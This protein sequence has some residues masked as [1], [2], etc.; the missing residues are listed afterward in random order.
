MPLISLNVVGAGVV[1]AEPGAPLGTRL[2]AALAAAPHKPVVVMIHGFR[3]TPDVAYSNP[4]THILALDPRQDCWK[5]LSWPRH[6]G[7]GRNAEEGLAIGLGWQAQGTIWA[8]YA[9]A[10][11]AGVALAG[12]IAAIR[13]V[14]PG[15]K[16]DVVAHSLGARVVLAALPLA[17][18][19]A[20][21]RVI[22][23]AAAE[24]RTTAE[25]ARRT[26]AGQGA[27]FIN[28]VT[29]ENDLFDL[30]LEML[31]APP[32]PGCR[33]LGLGLAAPARNWLDMQVDQ[34]ATIAALAA[35]GHRIA[36]PHLRICHW[37]GYLRPGLFGLYRSLLSGPDSLPLSL[38]AGRLPPTRD[39]RWSRL[40]AMPQVHLPLPPARNASS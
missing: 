26:P 9:Q 2:A 33:A 18:P 24:F 14:D 12:L 17:E 34:P 31:V 23:L 10:A 8:A 27:E 21:G 15:R 11:R 38:L 25:A 30:G 19:G 4:H 35:L 1:P 40:F 39:P 16:V 13:A 37:S 3:F 5:A 7:F 20:V 22:L 36:P 29:R 6:L 28:I 32:V